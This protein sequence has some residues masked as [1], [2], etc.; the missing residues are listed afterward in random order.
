MHFQ[1]WPSMHR[2]AYYLF[3]PPLIIFT[4]NF[5]FWSNNITSALKHFKCR[6]IKIGPWAKS[7]SISPSNNHKIERML[8]KLL[9]V[10]TLFK[11]KAIDLSV[12]V[13][14]Y[15]EW[16]FEEALKNACP[17]LLYILRSLSGSNASGIKKSKRDEEKWKKDMHAHVHKYNAH[18]KR[19]RN[20]GSICMPPIYH[21]VK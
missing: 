5:E 1:M 3:T 13:S 7:K 16:I 18:Y 11:Q 6:I 17:F 14:A 20:A 9:F 15:C 10:Y 12:F 21:G 8:L 19:I 4:G 2:T